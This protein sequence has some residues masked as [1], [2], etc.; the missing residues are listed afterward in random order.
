MRNVCGGAVLGGSGVMGMSSQLS[1]VRS[2]IAQKELENVQYF[3]NLGNLITNDAKCTRDITIRIFRAKTP[4]SV[5]TFFFHQ[6]FGLKYKEEKVKVLQLKHS[7]V[8]C[9]NWNSCVRCWSWNIAAC[10]VGTGT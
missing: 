9:W 7:V 6:Q 5:N 2:V 3:E 1:A 10:G 8:R 4:L